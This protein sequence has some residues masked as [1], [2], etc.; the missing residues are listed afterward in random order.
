MSMS[1]VRVRCVLVVVDEPRMGVRVAMRF[2]GRVA[3]AVFVLVMFVVDVH[4][5]VLERLVDMDV[6]VPLTK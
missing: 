3:G 1:V 5:L 6:R 4:M 2:R